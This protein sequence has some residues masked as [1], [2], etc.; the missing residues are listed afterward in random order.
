[1]SHVP[2]AP[3]G[4]H[5]MSWRLVHTSPPRIAMPSDAILGAVAIASSRLQASSFVNNRRA[6]LT[7]ASSRYGAMSKL[8]TSIPL[9]FRCQP[10]LDRRQDLGFEIGS[11]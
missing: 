11:P 3:I 4:I 7:V 9:L 1:V 6:F 10:L 2:P 8:R 5:F